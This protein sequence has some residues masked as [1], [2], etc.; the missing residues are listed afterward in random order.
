MR[1]VF[2]HTDF[3]L[4]WIQRFL[5]LGDFLSGMGHN[6]HVLE[7]AGEGSPY[8]FSNNYQDSASIEK[9]Q[10][11]WDCLFPNGEMRQLDGTIVRKAVFKCLSELKPD[12]IFAGAIAYPSGANA[13]AWG[14]KN[15]VPVVIFDDARLADVPRSWLV[16]FVKRRLYANISAMLIP[17]P[18]HLSDYRFWNIPDNNIYY[19]LDI[20]D[21]DFWRK[22]SVENSVPGELT[23]HPYILGVGRQI[24]KKNWLSVVEAYHR[25]GIDVNLVLVGNG[26]ERGKIEAL[27]H[28]LGLDDKVLLLDFLPPE[29]LAPLYANAQ[30]VLLCSSYGETWGLCVN[31]AMACGTPVLVSTE[32]G[33][34]ETLCIGGVTGWR[35]GTDIE[36]ISRALKS[37]SA[38]SSEQY[39]RIRR[40]V[41]TLIDQWGCDRFCKSILAIIEK[42]VGNPAQ[43]KPTIL[44]KLILML[45]KGRYRPV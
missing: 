15:N 31:E 27:R 35:S 36:S 26:P 8:A 28:R 43:V 44:N 4:Y 2:L 33:C 22:L 34:C 25:S 23:Q 10:V 6:L 19:G 24:P 45:W 38:T 21:N 17:A 37:F 16:N 7:I 20:I 12:I 3:R 1:I 9:K 18:S 41:Q 13:V 40:N 32:C 5:L 39:T 14:A 30:L 29:K 42:H 11:K